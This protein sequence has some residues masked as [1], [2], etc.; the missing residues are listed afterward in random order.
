MCLNLKAFKRGAVL[1]RSTKLNVDLCGFFFDKKRNSIK[2]QIWKIKYRT[3]RKREIPKT[4]LAIYYIY[5][6]HPDPYK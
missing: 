1:K 4:F 6:Q 5:P 2:I 3:Y